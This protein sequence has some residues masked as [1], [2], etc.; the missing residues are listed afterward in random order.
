M[1]SDSQLK[2][3]A[4]R[5]EAS[6]QFEEALALYERVLR[7]ASDDPDAMPDPTLQ[8]R[9]ADLHYRLGRR[10]VA[11]EEYGRAAALYRELGLLV[12]AIA[13][14][15]KVARLYEEEPE[16][17]QRLAG[18][19]VAMGLVADARSSLRSFVDACSGPERDGD[20]AEALT[21]FLEATPDP[22]VAT[23]LARWLAERELR[24]PAALETLE[25]VQRHLADE[26][27]W[28]AEL[29]EALRALQ[30]GEA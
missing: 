20:V 11:L 9:I 3:R 16:P 23:M 30:D 24:P 5:L 17:H 2:S 14:W 15:K 7:R 13:V 12:N 6:G 25:R 18:L 8:L 4:R 19:Q 27:R 29:D 21:G 26:G 22:A 28:G 1:D 10:G